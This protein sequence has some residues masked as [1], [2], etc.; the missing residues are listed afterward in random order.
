MSTFRRFTIHVSC[1]IR[2]NHG[3]EVFLRLPDARYDDVIGDVTEKAGQVVRPNPDN[4]DV[5][6]GRRLEERLPRV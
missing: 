3:N 4:V 5:Q 2:C 1:Y 6:P